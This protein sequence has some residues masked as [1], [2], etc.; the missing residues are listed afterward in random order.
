MYEN[1]AREYS[2]VNTRTGFHNVTRMTTALGSFFEK[3][4]KYSCRILKSEFHNKVEN[5]ACC[6][7]SV[8]ELVLGNLLGGSL[9][10]HSLHVC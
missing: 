2:N 5:Q 7:L 1:L 10:S 8:N 4:S 3:I 6:F 9:A